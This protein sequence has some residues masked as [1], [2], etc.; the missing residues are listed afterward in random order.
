MDYVFDTL[1]L[2]DDSPEAVARREAWLG[3]VERA[4]HGARPSSEHIAHWLSGARADGAVCRGAWLPEGEFGAGPAPVA[5]FVSFDKT[6]NAGHDLL[7]VRMISDVSASPTHRRRGLVRTMMESD[8][9]DAAT[10]GIPLAALT[11]SEATIYGRWG[12]GP[13]TFVRTFELDT[14]PRFGL[15]GF[16]DPGRVELVEPA[17]AWPHISQVF[18]QVHRTRR[19]SIDRPSFYEVLHTGAYDLA[20]G[21]P[22]K[23]LRGAV[24][25][26]TRGAADGVVLYQFDGSD[27][28][29]PAV[30]VHELLA[31]GAGAGL[32]LWN[33]LAHIDLSHRVVWKFGDP[34]D[35]LPWALTDLNALAVKAEREFLWLRVLDVQ[36]VLTARPWTADGAVILEVED[37]QGHAAGTYAIETLA[38]RATVARTTDR[39]EVTVT[40]E[41]LATLCLG[42]VSVTDLAAAGRVAGAPD[43][44]GR[45]AAMADRTDRPYTSTFF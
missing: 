3:A 12:F 31:A 45:F 14:G 1:D 27:A 40:A 16:T 20:D 30:A 35:P 5:T 26:D 10:R 9:A 37:A 13:A 2:S 23:K 33:F 15:R 18:E 44:V 19:G 25:L 4:F 11:A 7:P 8:L 32:A 24:H 21:G 43:A 39:P 22:A 41:T 38:G 6:I 29:K 42:A 17:E 36:R 34:S 28:E